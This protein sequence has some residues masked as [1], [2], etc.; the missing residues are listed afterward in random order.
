MAMNDYIVQSTTIDHGHTTS[1]A[2]RH[3][4]LRAARPSNANAVCNISA[5][6]ANDA[7]FAKHTT[8][9]VQ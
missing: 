9:N 4:H 1:T 2:A 7:I 3:G 8:F 6:N 5:S